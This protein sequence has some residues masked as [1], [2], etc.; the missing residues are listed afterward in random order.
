MQVNMSLRKTKPKA[1]KSYGSISHEKDFNY[2]YYL[3]TE[4][5]F[6]T[7]R[8]AIFRYYCVEF[9]FPLP[10]WTRKPRKICTR[11]KFYAFYEN[12]E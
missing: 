7:Q 10:E 4:T 2:G 1:D 5:Y 3:C 12:T 9:K 11:E 8:V 6:M